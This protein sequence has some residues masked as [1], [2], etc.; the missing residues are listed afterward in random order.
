MKRTTK[1]LGQTL[2]GSMMTR[3]LL[4]TTLLATQ[5]V[6]AQA[7]DATR[8][9][10]AKTLSNMGFESSDKNVYIS[11]ES[12]GKAADAYNSYDDNASIYAT[13]TTGTD[14]A[15]VSAK[16]FIGR[17]NSTGTQWTYTTSGSD[18]RRNGTERFADAQIEVPTGASLT[19]IRVWANDTDASN[20]MTIFL[21]EH[22]QPGFA[23]GPITSTTLA[24]M[25]TSGATGDQSLLVNLGS[26][27]VNNQDCIYLAR[28]RFDSAGSALRL[29]KVRLQ[30]TR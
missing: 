22:C 26:R 24:T 8:V 7:V 21:F 29:Q 4:C 23:A 17:S 28:A 1:H 14:H 5:F 15:G 6:A 12:L 11:N 20:D 19:F 2:L 10:D 30:F 3:V 27:A 9:T 25:T 16:E 13:P 18:L